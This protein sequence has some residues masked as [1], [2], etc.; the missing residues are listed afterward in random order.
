LA[1]AGADSIEHGYFAASTT[2]DP[3]DEALAD[4]LATAGISWSTAIR[5]PS[6]VLWFASE[7][8]TSRA[9]G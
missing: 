1:D 2:V 8:C 4:S 3:F 7:G 9:G 6:F 5:L